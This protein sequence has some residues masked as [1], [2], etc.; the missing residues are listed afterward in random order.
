MRTCSRAFLVASL[1]VPASLAAQAP[2]RNDRF[3]VL[4][5]AHR[6]AGAVPDSIALRLDRQRVYR[7]EIS[8]VRGAPDIRPPGHGAPAFS[9][10]IAGQSGPAIRRY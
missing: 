3:P 5:L 6:Y 7:V 4:S 8:G 1:A 9:A 2:A 10:L